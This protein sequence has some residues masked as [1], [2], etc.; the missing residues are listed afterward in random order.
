MLTRIGHDNK[1]GFAGWLLDKVII[2]VPSLGQ[3][4]VFPC[5]RWL[6]K[7]KDDGKLERELNIAEDSA[8]V[9]RPHI[10]YEITVYTSDVQGAGTS[11]N[12]FVVL[13]GVEGST[14]EVVLADTDK[15][16]KGTFNRASVNQFVKELDDI[17]PVIEKIRIGHDNKGLGAGW[18]L[19]KVEIRRLSD[20]D[21]SST[22]HTFP[23]NSWLAKDEGD[24]AIVRELVPQK[25]VEETVRR[26]GE[27]ETNEVEQYTLEMTQG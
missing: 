9:Y 27:V 3:N 6:D 20:E 26:D 5:G 24:G 7:D 10:P 17:G 13:C 18:H 11:A 14:K 21:G 1:G 23:C 12:V 16:K 22:T 19:E 15:K 25:V 2:D 4:V 8:Q